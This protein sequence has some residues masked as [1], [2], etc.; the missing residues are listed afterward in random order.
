MEERPSE[1]VIPPDM[2]ADLEKQQMIRESL[3]QLPARCRQMIEM[4][5][6][7]HPPMPYEDVARSLN[8]ARGS[9]GFIRGRCLQRLR[10]ILEDKGF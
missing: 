9:I 10:R 3:E 1:D 2:L 4:L 6:F 8:L 7:N 5:F